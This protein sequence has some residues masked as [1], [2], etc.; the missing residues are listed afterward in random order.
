MT[1]IGAAAPPFPVLNSER[2]QLREI[3][4]GDV[5]AMFAIHGDPELMKWFGNPVADREGATQLI[6]LL[7][8]WRLLPDPGVRWGLE[9]RDT[10]GLI[11][12]CG[13]FGWSRSDRKCT[14]GYEL[15]TA[16]QG[17]GFMH[18]AVV[19][20]VAWGWKHMDLVRI[21]ARI[22]PDNLASQRVVDRV[23]FEREGLLRKVA[24]FGGA[25]QDLLVYSLIR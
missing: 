19:T 13:L 22:H 1:D 20:A 15:A 21:E 11:G 23:G 12:S 8:G 7:A 9:R 6:D 10:P 25:H 3:T 24:F 17:Q 14:I 4:H 2:L 5:D 16:A 18:E